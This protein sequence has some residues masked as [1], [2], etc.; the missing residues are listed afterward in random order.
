LLIMCW[1]DGRYCTKHH[2]VCA[3]DKGG[4]LHYFKSSISDK[5]A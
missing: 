5:Y 4:I 2:R 3:K 1:L